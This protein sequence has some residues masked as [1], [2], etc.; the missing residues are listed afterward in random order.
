MSALESMI[1][2]NGAAPIHASL[3]YEPSTA[4]TDRK[5]HCRAYPSSASSLNPSGTKSVRIRLGE[6]DWIDPSSI[7]LLFTI[8]NNLADKAL[9]PTCGAYG[10]WQQAYLRSNGCETDNIPFYGRFHHQYGF[11]QS[12]REH[13]WGEAAVE[14]LY[15]S[16]AEAGGDYQ[17][18]QVGVINA[19]KSFTVMHKLHFLLF[20]AGKLLPVK[21][22]PMEVELSI[23]N[24]LTDWLSSGSTAS[25]DFTLSDIQIIYDAYVLD[26]AVQQAFFT[27]LMRNRVLSVPTMNAYQICHPL[28]DG[29][30][31]YSFSNVRAFSRLVDLPRNGV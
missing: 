30:T 31:T 12:S 26:E 5:Q 8:K 11:N 24:D 17:R 20:S 13:Q 1:A 4:V 29:A 6:E 10:V 2:S 21:Y 18:P 15:T 23:V 3:S 19:S 22:A 27:S 16:A 14:G 9:K 7:R 25:L 28:P